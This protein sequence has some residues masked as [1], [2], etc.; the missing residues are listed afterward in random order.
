ML[1]LRRMQEKEYSEYRRFFIS[2][3]AT[4]L[5]ENYG[6]ESDFAQEVA[7]R[8]IDG[9]L[10]QGVSEGVETLFCIVAALPEESVVG[11]LWYGMIDAGK[12][13]YIKDFCILDKFQ[14]RG[15][16]RAALNALDSHLALQGIAEVKL[17]VAANNPNARALYESTDFVVTGYNMSKKVKL[18]SD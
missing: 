10:P 14:R 12:S 7:T 3:Y 15:F 2:E 6:Y 1:E 8:A 16:G 18:S 11:Y 17:R 13:A 9:D 4:D 5:S